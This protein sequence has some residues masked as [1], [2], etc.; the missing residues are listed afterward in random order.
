ME[1]VSGENL[2]VSWQFSAR[3]NNYDKS[4]TMQT[5]KHA[6]LVIFDFFFLIIGMQTLKKFDVCWVNQFFKRKTWC[7]WT[8]FSF[9]SSRNCY[10]KLPKKSNELTLKSRKWA[11]SM[12]AA[13]KL[14][15][16]RDYSPF[17]RL[18]LRFSKREQTLETNP[19]CKI[20]ERERANKFGLVFHLHLFNFMFF[21]WK[22]SQK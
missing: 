16:G 17:S 19:L 14:N 1:G 7:I 12:R 2:E 9:N 21:F 3:E 13:C 6:K 15:F 22:M 8:L 20:D 18:K 4:V 5:W 11:I 10:L